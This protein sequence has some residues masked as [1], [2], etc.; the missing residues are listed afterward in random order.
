M[1]GQHGEVPVQL[2]ALLDA[3][4]DP[5]KLQRIQAEVGASASSEAKDVSLVHQSRITR[6][7]TRKYR[8][9]PPDTISAFLLSKPGFTGRC[10][11]SSKASASRQARRNPK[12]E[13]GS[14]TSEEYDTG[15]AQ[16]HAIA[17]A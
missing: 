8:L 9:G 1:H 12:I 6:V 16:K 4:Q 5:V 13:S 3:E 7:L 15:R 2:R 17:Y 11:G 14:R 10:C